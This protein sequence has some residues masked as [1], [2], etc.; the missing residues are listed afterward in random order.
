MNSMNLNSYTMLSPQSPPIYSIIEQVLSELDPT[1]YS[2]ILRQVS[3]PIEKLI[4]PKKKSRKGNIPRPQNSFVIY[5]RDFMAKVKLNY[6][7]EI[8][9]NLPFVSTKAAKWWS[10]ENSEVKNTYQIIADLARKVHIRVYPNYVFKPK[11]RPNKYTIKDIFFEDIPPQQQM[12]QPIPS[13]PLS[14]SSNSN[15]DNNNSQPLPSINQ[16]LSIAD[17]NN[18]YDRRM[19]R[20]FRGPY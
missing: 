9:S 15:S 4:C 13:P 14:N 12:N 3:L 1:A 11:K 17:D 5:R 6:G 18:N 19:C 16:L 7:H 10:S 2:K 20:S 8:S